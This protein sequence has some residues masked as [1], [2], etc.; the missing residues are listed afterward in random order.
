MKGGAPRAFTVDLWYPAASGGTP[1][2]QL[3]AILTGS[4]L[5]KRARASAVADAPVAQLDAPLPLL[6]YA[7]GW[8]GPRWAN[9]FILANLA[10]HGY[11]VA[12][13]DD[14]GF[15][16]SGV[17]RPELG[18]LDLST[19]EASARS[20][21]SANKRLKLMVARVSATI[22]GLA[23]LD[24]DGRLALLG[25]RVDYAR[26]GML[27]FSFG[28][29]VAAESALSEPR[30]VAAANM[31]GWLFGASATTIIEKPYLAFNSDLPTIEEDA[32]VSNHRRRLTARVTLSDRAQQRRQARRPDAV[33]LLFKQVD[34]ADFSDDLFS[35]QLAGYLKRWSRTS[36]A[37]LRLGA[38]QDAYL[39]AFFNRHLRGSPA[40]ALLQRSPPPFPGVELLAPH[41]SASR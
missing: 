16:P 26:V 34:H 37:R 35:P 8:D 22:D 4:G 32:K 24:R 30:L 38:V 1:A 19:D 21:D 18:E 5:N 23:S 25:G 10:S 15:S 39:L 41:V 28:G 36:D 13:I 6:I 12:A 2:G 29:A 17:P 40:S 11:V 9:T 7:P 14:V 33:I 3:G 27:G 20:F 31:D